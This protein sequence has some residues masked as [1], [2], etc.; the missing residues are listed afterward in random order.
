LLRGKLIYLSASKKKEQ[1]TYTRTLTVQPSTLEQNNANR[2]KK[3]RRQEIIK[4]RVEIYQV[5]TKRTIQRINQTRIWFFETINK[6]D[7]LLAR[8]TR[9]Q[10]D[11]I[12]INKIRKENGNIT[13]KTE[14]I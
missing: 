2:P 10:R 6:I 3:S 4:L 11:S 7:K 5:E 14:E 12:L 1:R 9:G 8:L 13:M